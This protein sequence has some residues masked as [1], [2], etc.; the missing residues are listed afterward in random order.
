MIGWIVS[1]NEIVIVS[2]GSTRGGGSFTSSSKLL[3]EHA[4]SKPNSSKGKKNNA[5]TLILSKIDHREKSKQM[6][7]RQIRKKIRNLHNAPFS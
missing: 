2:Q 5:L 6:F 3:N 4:E 7:Q 1:A